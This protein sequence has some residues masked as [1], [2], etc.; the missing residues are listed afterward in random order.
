MFGTFVSGQN[1]VN[2][3]SGLRQGMSLLL[4]LSIFIYFSK[5]PT[6]QENQKQ[7]FSTRAETLKKFREE[8]KKPCTCRYE[9]WAG[10]ENKL[11]CLNCL[12]KRNLENELQK[13]CFWTDLKHLKYWKVRRQG[14]YKE[15]KIAPVYPPIDWSKASC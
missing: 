15:L 8:Q 13:K 5:M 14:Q 3:T 2:L 9:V 12:R 1:T 10:N 7:Y 11:T 4:S 6:Y